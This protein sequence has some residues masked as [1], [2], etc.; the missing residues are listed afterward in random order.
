VGAAGVVPGGQ[1]CVPRLPNNTCGSLLEAMK[2][3]K[4]METAFTGYMVWFTDSRGWND[5]PQNT[6]V[7]WPVPYQEMQARQQTY[8]NGTRQQ[9][10]ASTYG[11]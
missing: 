3:E 10:G 7:E 2:Y 9:T 1:A 4:R 11:F 8:Y 6:V 5:L